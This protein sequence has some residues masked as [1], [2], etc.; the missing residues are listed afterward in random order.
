MKRIVYFDACIF[1]AWL[2]NERR[3]DPD[4]LKAVQQI[5]DKVKKRELTVITST[6]TQVEVAACKVGKP[7][8]SKFDDLLKRKNLQRISV[9]IKTANMA[10]ELRDAYNSASFKSKSNTFTPLDAIHLATAILNRVNNFYTFD[11]ELINHS[12]SNKIYNLT[13]GKPPCELSFL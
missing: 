8:L 5:I 11:N 1:I 10:R 2:K 3:N 7:I 12:N 9:D 4:D 13:I 6:I